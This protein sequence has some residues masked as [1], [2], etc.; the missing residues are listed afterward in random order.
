MKKDKPKEAVIGDKVNNNLRTRVNIFAK[1]DD[2][3]EGKTQAQ[4]EQEQKAK[5]IEE[6][7]NIK[8][9]YLDKRSKIKLSD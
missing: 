7:E 2:K 3:K 8:N 6:I 5:E 4:I 1:K 9:K